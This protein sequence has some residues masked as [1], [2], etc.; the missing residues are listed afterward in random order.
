MSGWERWK[1]YCAKQAEIP[2]EPC[3]NCHAPGPH[4]L[5]VFGMVVCWACYRARFGSYERRRV[6]EGAA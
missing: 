2:P 6:A 4:F 3:A 5:L 1:A